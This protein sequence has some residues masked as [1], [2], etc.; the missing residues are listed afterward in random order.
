MGI[1]LEMV[2]HD[3]LFE[4][5]KNV[6]IIVN[7]FDLEVKDDLNRL[8]ALIHTT[9][10]KNVL[11]LLPQCD[12]QYLKGGR[13]VGVRCPKCNT[14]C[15]SVT[16]K[17]LQS[18]LWIATPEGIDTL[19]NPEAWIILSKALTTSQF[20]IL[21]WLTD[22][23]KA[24][25]T[26]KV[27]GIL[28]RI[29]AAGFQRGINAFYAQ[30]DQLMQFLIAERV[31]KKHNPRQREEYMQFIAE[32]RHAI[33]SKHLP[34]PSKLALIT[35]K[36]AKKTTVDPVMVPAIEAVRT[37]SGIKN[38]VLT[39]SLKRK[40]SKTVKAIK[41]LVDYY[42]GFFQTSL[43]AKQ[44]WFR[45]HTYGSRIHFSFRAVISS[46]SEPHVYDEVHL[47]WSLSVMF[48]KFHLISKLMNRP[49]LQYSPN[50]AIGLLN[51][52]TQSY[53][54]LIDELFQQLIAES[55]MGGI[56]IGLQ[57]NPS[58]TRGS[59]QTLRVTKIKTNPAI[60]TI[61]LSLLILRSYN[62]IFVASR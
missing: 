7:E 4:H 49:D 55:P 58:L 51:D 52:H 42:T 38:S 9:Y 44:G 40:E 34:V 14:L 60:N 35:E 8:N 62:K 19:I 16:E 33:F 27:Q 46:L 28:D 10:E 5:S 59:F 50:Q 13:N 56:V 1:Y 23:Y 36:S 12:C 29:T 54:P 43:P 20:N 39:L 3:E 32:N 22:P 37:I 15:L 2:D 11:Q 24:V 26:N 61:S 31:I 41:Y 21:E 6:A 17:P 30:F 57:R 53:N 47:P 45:K 48:L 25:T 18:A